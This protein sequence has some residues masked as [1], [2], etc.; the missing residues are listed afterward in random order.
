MSDKLKRV[1][2]KVGTSTLTHPSGALN[3]RHVEELVKVI[4]DIRNSGVE[5]VLV[6][7]G[8]IGLGAARLGLKE[9]PKDTP[10][11]QACAAVGQCELMNIYEKQFNEYGITAAQVLLTKFVLTDERK[12]NVINSLGRLIEFGTI[13][14]VNENDV[15]AIDELELE[16]GEND[17]LAAIVA[18]ITNADTLIIMSDIDGLYE[19]DPKINSNAKL[20]SKIT[21]IS[22]ELVKMAGG[23][24]SG[25]GTGG[26]ATK[27]RAAKLA[28]SQNIDMMII[29]GKR[30]ANLYDVFDGKQIG[31]LFTTDKE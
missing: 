8:A 30:P 18:M 6:T 22:D 21:E 29:N 23:S 13:P 7:S 17:S 4:S 15:V 3:I 19:C 25:L 26:M 24:A 27:L 10:T 9:R 20:I 31:T 1:V 2:I 14:I 5:I 11:K 12:E 28:M 16:V